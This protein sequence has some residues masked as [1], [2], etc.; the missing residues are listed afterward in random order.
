M[1]SFH[2]LHYNY[3]YTQLPSMLFVG[4]SNL[5]VGLLTV[6]GVSYEASVQLMHSQAINSSL[7]RRWSA[8][9][10]R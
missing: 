2:E 7:M 1:K 5:D 9:E 8:I 10:R 4:A 3:F 6:I